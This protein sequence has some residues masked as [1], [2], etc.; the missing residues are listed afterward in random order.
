MV[1]FSKV[2]SHILGRCSYYA[3]QRFVLAP[4]AICYSVNIASDCTCIYGV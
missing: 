1:P 3:S 2:E 4:K